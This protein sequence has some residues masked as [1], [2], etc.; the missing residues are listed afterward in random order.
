[1]Y[2]PPPIPNP[3]SMSEME[4]KDRLHVVGQPLSHQEIQDQVN[5]LL[6]SSDEPS[7][8]LSKKIFELIANSGLSLEELKEMITNEEYLKD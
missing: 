6:S 8:F 4:D 7:E 5:K 1:M 2:T 3:L